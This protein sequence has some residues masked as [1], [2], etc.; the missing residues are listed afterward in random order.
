MKKFI[1]IFTLFEKKYWQF[2]NLN[3]LKNNFIGSL[4]LCVKVVKLA[5][6]IGA[7]STKNVV[8]TWG[9]IYFFLPI[10]Q[11]WYGNNCSNLISLSYRQ[12]RRRGRCGLQ[13]QPDQDVLPS[14]VY[15]KFNRKRTKYRTHLFINKPKNK[16]IRFMQCFTFNDSSTSQLITVYWLGERRAISA[17]CVD[18]KNPI[19]PIEFFA[20]TQS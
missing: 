3:I 15:L 10:C 20:N 8:L 9:I 4:N 11:R 16:K 18:Q 7:F 1:Q 5:K 13:K 19:H 6:F 17:C 12:S 2:K 14:F